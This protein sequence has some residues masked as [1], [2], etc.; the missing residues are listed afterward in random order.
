MKEEQYKALVGINIII[1]IE[2]LENDATTLEIYRKLDYLH[3]KLPVELKYY[4]VSTKKEFLE[5]LE[6]IYRSPL[7]VP[8]LHLATHGSA[9]GIRLLN[10]F[11]A[12]D[13][14][15]PILQKIN[16][17][18]KNSL[19]VI[20]ALCYGV[21]AID[22]IT[23]NERAPFGLMIGP[24]DKINWGLLDNYLLKFYEALMR[25]R[26]INKAIQA[27]VDFSET[28]K[29]PFIL[30]TPHRLIHELMEHLTKIIR[31]G[32]ARHNLFKA[33]KDVNDENMPYEL[34]ANLQTEEEILA[35]YE[36]KWQEIIEK[37]LMLDVY[38][39]LKDYVTVPS[40]SEFYKKSK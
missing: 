6:D 40:L 35:F 39:E 9:E 12:W 25:E 23:D 10:G 21:H 8:L 17:R 37:Y 2:S 34:K 14:F 7:A 27:M 30:L 3:Y 32:Q 28:G 31:S 16:F 5:L 4:K 19:I 15:L 11:V 29:I 1:V 26:D 33:Y 13:E 38:P 24:Q 20:M 22:G 18:T 36:S